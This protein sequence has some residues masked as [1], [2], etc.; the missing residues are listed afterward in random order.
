MGGVLVVRE[1]AY[2]LTPPLKESPSDPSSPEE[3]RG[4][5]VVD[6]AAEAGLSGAVNIYG[7]VKTKRYLLEEM[8]GGVAFFDYDHDGW[9][10]IF[11]VNGARLQSQV[12]KVL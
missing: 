3:P 8:G 7:G 10:D 1:D 12:L 9:L 5:T 11:F 6:A 2:G 4:V